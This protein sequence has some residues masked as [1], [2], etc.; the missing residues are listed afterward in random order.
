MSSIL[1]GNA[2]GLSDAERTNPIWAEDD[3]APK[4]CDV[5]YEFGLTLAIPLALAL[6][7]NGCLW[8]A[9]APIP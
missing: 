3:Q 9:G 7:A 8:A 6:A 4:A 2:W 1:H 5:Q